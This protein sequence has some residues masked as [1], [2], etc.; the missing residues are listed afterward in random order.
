MSADMFVD[1]TVDATVGAEQI[2]WN[3]DV[4][5]EAIFA[6]SLQPSEAPSTDAV[7]TAA[8]RALLDLGVRGCAACVAAEFGDHPETAVARMKWARKLLV[9]AGVLA[10]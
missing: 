8:A 5:L 9:L 7:R 2:N 4:L 10:A 1:I 6:S 3:I